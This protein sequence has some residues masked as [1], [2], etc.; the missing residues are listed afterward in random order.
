LGYA[1][2]ATGKKAE[3]LTAWTQVADSGVEGTLAAEAL[4]SQA[5]VQVA[6]GKKAEAQKALERALTVAPG[7]EMAQ[8]AERLKATLP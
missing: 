4:I 6:L 7:S 8:R 5:R 2:E 3:A 1:L